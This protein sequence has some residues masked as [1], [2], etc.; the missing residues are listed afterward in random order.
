MH[1]LAYWT[2]GDNEFL[3]KIAPVTTAQNGFTHTWTPARGFWTERHAAFKLLANVVAY[4]VLG[5]TPRRDTV[6]Q[7]LADFRAHQDG[8]GGQVPSPR[9]DGGLYHLGSQHDGDWAD[10]SY[11]G[12]SWMTVLLADAVVRSYAT[13][14]DAQTA[15]FMRE[16]AISLLPPSSKPPNTVTTRGGVALP[17]YGMLRDG[18]DG[19]INAED[20]EHALDVA[21]NGV[22]ALFRELSG[23]DGAR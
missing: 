22:G 9:I 8:A 15:Q 11:G 18:S 20:V 13:G 4:E 12:S 17:R 16:S 3:A 14:E 2:T 23:G 7:I 10:G 5:S 6:N 19:Q 1:R 21:G